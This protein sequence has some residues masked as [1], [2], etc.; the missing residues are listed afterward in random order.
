MNPA[1]FSPI[2]KP[3][4]IPLPE[5]E[6]AERGGSFG[7]LL[8]EASDRLSQVQNDADKELRSLLAGESVDLHRVL[9]AGERAGLASQL[10]MSV[11]NK[12]V[13]AYQEIMRMQV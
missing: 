8:S 6:S 10:M 13:D 1:G 12:V 5:I 9:L 11:R 2:T 7:D 3:T 4:L